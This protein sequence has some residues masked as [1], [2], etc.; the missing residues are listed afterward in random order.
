[1]PFREARQVHRDDRPA[2]SRDL[3]RRWKPAPS[4]PVRA[5]RSRPPKESQ[6]CA[7]HSLM[8][9]IGPCATSAQLG[10]AHQAASGGATTRGGPTAA[11]PQHLVVRLPQLPASGCVKRRAHVDAQLTTPIRSAAQAFPRRRRGAVRV[12]VSVRPRFPLAANLQEEN[13]ETIARHSAHAGI[14]GSRRLC[15]RVSG[16]AFAG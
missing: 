9:T 15:V 3:S 10:Q 5:L 13:T 16:S 1:M 7:T 8:A 14:S 6:F 4:T 12:D 2:D 11:T